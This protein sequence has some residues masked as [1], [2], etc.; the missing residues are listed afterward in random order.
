MEKTIYP[1]FDGFM[2]MISSLNS[3][4]DLKDI[5][6]TIKK[7]TRND[8]EDDLINSYVFDDFNLLKIHEISFLKQ[9]N[10]LN[11]STDLNEINKI[12]LD[13]I[14]KTNDE[15]QLKVIEII[16]NKKVN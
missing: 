10:L 15:V 5:Y 9:I 2:K 4:Q 12:K 6:N 8:I 3:H 16:Y 14:K 11:K 13:L 7:Y 1:I